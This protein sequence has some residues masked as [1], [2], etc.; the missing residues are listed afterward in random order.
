MASHNHDSLSKHTHEMCTVLT[1]K[2]VYGLLEMLELLSSDF[3][4]ILLVALEQIY[5]TF[6]MNL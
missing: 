6:R 2:N 4:Q 3:I 5:P 1:E